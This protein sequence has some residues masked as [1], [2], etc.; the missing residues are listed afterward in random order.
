MGYS[1]TTMARQA[2]GL[3]IATEQFG[4]ASLRE[5]GQTRRHILRTPEEAIE[6]AR[7]GEARLR[8][9]FENIH[10][11]T[12]NAHRTAV[13]EEGTDW[14]NTQIN[15]DD[16]QF[17]STRQFQVLEIAR[18]FNV[19]P[20]KIGDYSQAHLTNVEESNL[21]YLSTTL[22]G[23]L[24]AIE[25]EFNAKLLFDDER[26]E[27]FFSHNMNALMRANMAARATY[28]E[29]R[30]RTA[31]ITP[32]QIRMAEGENPEPPEKGLDQYLIQ[33]QYV[34]I[35]QAGKVMAAKAGVGEPVAD[36]PAKTKRV[37]SKRRM[38]PHHGEDGRFS[39]AGGA[40]VG[41]ANGLGE[42]LADH[43]DSIGELVKEPGHAAPSD[44][45]HG[46]REQHT[47]LV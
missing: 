47:E 28:Y 10:G 45:E 5:R 3:G 1:P 41:R 42:S 33:T 32:N 20:H 22:Q 29:S 38:N 36:P 4:A 14:I 15:P 13:I 24:E 19:P 9:T 17:L 8:E 34:P 11:G 6:H 37:D 26:D 7:R 43:D 12:L 25:A 46:A 39:D 16:A 18:I 35:E 23:W 2:I 31:S 44:W 40:L 30:F 27:L 21:D